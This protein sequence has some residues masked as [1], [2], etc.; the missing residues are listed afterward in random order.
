MLNTLIIKNSA[1]IDTLKIDFHSR[2]NVITGETG[3]GKSIII[4]ALQLLVG[5]RAAKNDRQ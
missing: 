2:H 1:L 3:A 5:Q 4:G